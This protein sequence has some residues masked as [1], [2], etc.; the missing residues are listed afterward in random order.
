MHRGR[1]AGEGAEGREGREN[2]AGCG[3]REE[4]R[5]LQKKPTLVVERRPRVVLDTLRE[6]SRGNA[7]RWSIF[8]GQ[9]LENVGD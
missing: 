9:P 7:R 4:L 8:F 2:P 5:G 3:A 6:Q 1:Q